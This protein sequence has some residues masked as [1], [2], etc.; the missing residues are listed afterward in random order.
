MYREVKRGPTAGGT[1]SGVW[2]IH[3]D[4]L[5][6]A[7]TEEEEEEE[8][9]GETGG[10]REG[11]RVEIAVVKPNPPPRYIAA[12]TIAC[13]ASLHSQLGHLPR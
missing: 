8:G 4:A 5:L 10:A 12:Y 1:W 2:Q 11:E 6:V 9:S 3:V 7:P 13:R